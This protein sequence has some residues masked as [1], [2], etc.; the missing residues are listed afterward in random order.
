L[1]RPI[2]TAIVIPVRSGGLEGEPRRVLGRHQP[3]HGRAHDR[4]PRRSPGTHQ[5]P[6]GAGDTGGAGD[7]ADG[8]QPEQRQDV[9]KAR[10]PGLELAERA[11]H[12]GLGV[13]RHV[14]EDEGE[15]ACREHRETDA[16][17][18]VDP[19]QPTHGKAEVDRYA[20]DCSQ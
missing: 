8:E 15:D 11:L 19:P 7:E 10:V 16:H 4:G 5:A 12:D 18:L 3:G 9:R 13:R 2:A 1:C 6:L 14:H 17:A 20:G